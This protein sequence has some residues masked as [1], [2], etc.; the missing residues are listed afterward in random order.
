MYIH[1]NMVFVFN[2]T[3]SRTHIEFT[4]EMF[5]V[6]NGRLPIKMRLLNSYINY[7]DYRYNAEFSLKHMCI[8][9]SQWKLA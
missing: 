3:V 6:H 7:F 9:F 1:F 2:Q 8:T 5:T 4:V